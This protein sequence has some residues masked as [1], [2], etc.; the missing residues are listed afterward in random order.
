MKFGVNTFT[1]SATF[2]S[3]NFGL[4]ALIKEPGF[5]GVAVALLRPEAFAAPRALVS[6]SRI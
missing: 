6:R 2:D 3:S 1:W 5:D 4:L